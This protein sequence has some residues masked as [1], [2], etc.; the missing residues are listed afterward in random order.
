MLIISIDQ[1][2][3]HRHL[4]PGLEKAGSFLA[5]VDLQ[6]LTDGRYEI[7][8][9][10]LFAIVNTCAGKGRHGARLEAHR[11]YIDVQHCLSGKDIIG[12]WPLA[13]CTTAAAAYD[14][15]GDV[16]FFE[17]PVRQWISIEGSACAIFFPD[18]AHAPLAGVGPCKKI[19]L[20]VR[21]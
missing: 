6:S 7:D 19:V 15:A 20:K 8:G 10:E 17:D 11:N 2:Q 18:D 12:F 9:D 5:G 4:H 21:V 16:I 3:K 13:Q 1:L 14:E